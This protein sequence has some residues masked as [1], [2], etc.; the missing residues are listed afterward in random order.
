VDKRLEVESS[1]MGLY[2]HTPGAAGWRWRL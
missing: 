1:P 2:L